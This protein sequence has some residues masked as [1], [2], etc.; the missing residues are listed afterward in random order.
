M[1][2]IPGRL[3]QTTD[4]QLPNSLK[5]WRAS[6]LIWPWI[7][8]AIR[9]NSPCDESPAYLATLLYPANSAF[10]WLTCRVFLPYFVLNR[11]EIWAT[12]LV[13]VTGDWCRALPTWFHYV[14]IICVAV[15]SAHDKFDWR[16]LCV[17]QF[18]S[19]YGARR[20]LLGSL[21]VTIERKCD[22]YNLKSYKYVCIT[23]YQP[24]TKSNPNLN[25]NP[26]AKQ[27]AIVNI[28]L[29]IV[30]CLTHPD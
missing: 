10:H 20:N 23:T 15:F 1:L 29:N 4:R 6:L 26:T 9:T 18:N 22:N 27:H 28:Q 5:N 11:F 24:D 30:T 12:P 13:Q 21:I 14:C 17:C 25:P 3:H 2:N 19:R 7:S 16:A 8:T